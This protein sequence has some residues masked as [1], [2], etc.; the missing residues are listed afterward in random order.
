VKKF[1]FL[2]SL[3]VIF[4]SGCSGKN[5]I[6]ANIRQEQAIVST[7]KAIVKAADESILFLMATYFNNMQKY[8]DSKMDMIIFSYYYSPSSPQTKL[9]LGKPAV[10]LNGIS[11]EAVELENDNE[12]LKDVPINNVWNRYYLVTRK[13]NNETLR[14]NIEI[15]PFPSALLELSKEL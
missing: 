3:A 9:D 5:N 13:V 10:K 7:Q 8:S 14:L 6:N 12:L 15:Y 1:F 2:I 11:I 4:F